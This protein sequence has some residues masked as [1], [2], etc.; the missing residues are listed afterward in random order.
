[1]LLT[2]GSCTRWSIPLI[3]A[4]PPVSRSGL[5]QL[6]DDCP[7][8]YQGVTQHGSV[9]HENVRCPSRSSRRLCRLKVLCFAKTSPHACRVICHCRESL[10]ID[11]QFDQGNRFPPDGV[12]TSI[13]AARAR[14]QGC[15]S[16]PGVSRTS[17]C[18]S[19][20]GA[21]VS[22]WIGH[23]L[24]CRARFRVDPSMSVYFPC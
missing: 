18:G 3:R 6:P 19:R 14:S 22:P 13:R 21:S 1:M 9:T 4:T 16:Q 2:P 12:S 20:V 11:S 24:A 7:D 15:L 8:T 5:V 23:G 17:D 10:R